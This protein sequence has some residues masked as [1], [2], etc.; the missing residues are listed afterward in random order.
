VN[1]S[2]IENVEAV[3]KIRV[4]YNSEKLIQSVQRVCG[5]PVNL[6]KRAGR[7]ILNEG[8]KLLSRQFYLPKLLTQ[9]SKF[10]SYETCEL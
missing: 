10:P 8:A 7:S 9:E 1:I 2:E 4:V 6:P 5:N 3:F